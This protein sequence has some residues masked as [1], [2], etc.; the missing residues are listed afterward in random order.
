[1]T[2]SH[3]HDG[4]SARCARKTLRLIGWRVVGRLP[5]LPRCLVVF[6]PHTS[7]R[8]LPLMLLTKVALGARV[9]Y[10]AK[11]TL[12]RGP[13]ARLF[14]WTGA[15]A[16]DRREPHHLVNTIREMFAERGALW[17]ALAPEGTRSKTD[18]WKSG[19]YYI[20]LE[21]KLPVLLAFLD[22]RTKTCGVGPVLVLS[23]EVTRDLEQLRAF[24][25]D[26][27]GIRPELASDIRFRSASGARDV[28]D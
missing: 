13:F 21:A 8:D 24:Y 28:H 20:A 15:I 9:E 7:K 27:R 1:M 11:H 2:A 16:V 26:K 19:F 17:L 3:G 12:F 22:S 25:A 14:R 18:H 6:A 5:A 4:F 10:L 23:G